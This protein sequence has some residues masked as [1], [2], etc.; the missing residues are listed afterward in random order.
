MLCKNILLQRC[1]N[2]LSI[3]GLIPETHQLYVYSFVS[4]SCNGFGVKR[5]ST[6]YGG[7]GLFTHMAV[8]HPPHPI[9]NSSRNK[10]CVTG[11]W[12]DVFFLMIVFLVQKFKSWCY[13]YFVFWM[14]PKSLNGALLKGYIPTKSCIAMCRLLW[15]CSLFLNGFRIFY[16]IDIWP[17]WSFALVMLHPITVYRGV[18]GVRAV[19]LLKVVTTFISLLTLPVR[20]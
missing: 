10:R 2:L 14:H 15:F 3:K 8:I 6:G 5:W 11:R 13:E 7:W 12:D 17:M 19:R 20:V 1:Q 16:D 9:R 4:W 18:L